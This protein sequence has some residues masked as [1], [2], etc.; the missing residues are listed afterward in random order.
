MRLSRKRFLVW[1]LKPIEGKPDALRTRQVVFILV[2]VFGSLI[3][4]NLLAM[5]LVGIVQ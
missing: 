3:F 4:L 1:L 5:G 2:T